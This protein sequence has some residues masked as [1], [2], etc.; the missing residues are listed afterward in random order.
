MRQAKESY[1]QWIPQLLLCSPE[2]YS[3]ISLVWIPWTALVKGKGKALES[4]SLDLNPRHSLTSWAVLG[5]FFQS[6]RF[7]SLCIPASSERSVRQFMENTHLQNC[8][9][10]DADLVLLVS[11]LFRVKPDA[12]GDAAHTPDPSRAICNSA[13]CSLLCPLFPSFS[14]IPHVPSCLSFSHS[15][16]FSVTHTYAEALMAL[17]TKYQNFSGD[18]LLILLKYFHKMR[19]LLLSNLFYENSMI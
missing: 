7:S 4:D 6:L 1:I 14:S 17:L 10:V 13:F 18:I 5:S 12:V 15:L 8:L 16:F 19:K 3:V 11:L 9:I 2:K